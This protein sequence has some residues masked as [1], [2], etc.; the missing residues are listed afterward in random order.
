MPPAAEHRAPWPALVAVG[1]LGGLLS[2]L[3]GVGGGILMVPLLLWLTGMDQ[4]RAATTSLAAIV[5]T[6]LVGAL[7]YL[8]R[9]EVDVLVAALVAA[10]GVAGSWVGSW[11]LRRTPL[12]VLRWAFVGLLVLVAARMLLATDGT[13]STPQVGVA[14]GAALVGVG[15]LT[16]VTA[17]LFGIGGGVV[18]VPA[19]TL[20]LGVG[21]LLAKGTSLLVMLPTAAAGTFANVRARAVD[22]RAGLVVGVSA[23][24]ASFGGVALAFRLPDRLAGVLF[25]A[26]VLITAAQ[27]AVRAARAGRTSRPPGP[28]PDERDHGGREVR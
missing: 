5:P 22:V 27:L 17:G 20:L 1:V 15:L 3:F 7:S 25:A 16:G 11:L 8:A 19:L 28:G 2:G 9:G 23:S 24:V 12:R 10:G 21:P 18:V 13:G 4:R 6:S 14:T 26:L